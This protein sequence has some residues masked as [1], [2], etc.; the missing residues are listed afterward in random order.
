MKKLTFIT[1]D[2]GMKRSA[3]EVLEKRLRELT[4]ADPLRVAAVAEL[5]KDAVRPLIEIL[6]SSVSS[7]QLILKAIVI[8]IAI[9]DGGISNALVYLTLY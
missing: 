5:R 9:L 7:S 2:D 1:Q 3:A 6:G 4:A 8:L